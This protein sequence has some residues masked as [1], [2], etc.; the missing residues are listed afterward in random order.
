MFDRLIR[1]SIDQRWLV[2]LVVAALG[3]FNYQRL[4]VDAVANISNV[5]VVV[6][7]SAP[8]SSPL[9][10]EQRVTF[11][12]ETVIAGLPGLEQTRS[13]SRYGLSQV[14]AI[15]RGGTDIHF[16]RQLVNQRLQEA[17]ER[18]PTGIVPTMGPIS[19]GLGE[20]YLWTIEADEGARKSDGTP[21]TATDLREFQDWVVKPQLRTVTGVTE[22]NSIGGFEK[23][24][25]VAP[26]L[27]RLSAFG[28]SLADVVTA[29]ERHNDNRAP[30]TSSDAASRCWCGRR[31]S[32]DRSTTCATSSPAASKDRR[33]VFARSRRSR[34]DAT[35]ARAQR[36]R[37]VA[38]SCWVR[39]S[40]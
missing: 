29:I 13:L 6:N 12:I 21:Y 36:P 1:L 28:L 19:T 11:P 34:S 10:T 33:F 14:T 15:F 16:A 27:E 22:I 18:L 17:R 35:C 32:C 2:V 39:S 20:I 7:T 9:E 3:V 26:D 30:A 4:A 38:R 8:G 25:V 40:C 24:Y 31:D 37:T 5:Q 23:Q